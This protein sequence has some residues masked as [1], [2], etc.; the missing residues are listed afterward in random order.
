MYSKNNRIKKIHIII[1]IAFV[2]IYIL[3]NKY[4]FNNNY[5]EQQDQRPTSG[6]IDFKN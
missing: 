6:E 4:K 3:Y 5:S 1:I 2:F